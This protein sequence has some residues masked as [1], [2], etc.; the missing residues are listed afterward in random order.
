MNEFANIMLRHS[1]VFSLERNELS[2]AQKIIR[3]FFFQT[4][5]SRPAKRGD[6]VPY[7]FLTP[8]PMSRF[9]RLERDFCVFTPKFGGHAVSGSN[10]ILSS[11][12][13]AQSDKPT[14]DCLHRQITHHLITDG[15]TVSGVQVNNVAAF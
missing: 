15:S 1:C 11:I 8:S 6:F 3:N 9:A 7:S 2:H 4:D 5:T 13:K 12:I 14:A 10:G